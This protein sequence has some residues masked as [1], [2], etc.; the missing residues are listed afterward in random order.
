VTPRAAGLLGRDYWLVHSAPHDTTTPE[1]IAAVVDE[2]VEWLLGLESAGVVVLSGP[3]LDG[4]GARPGSGMTVLRAAD[5]DAA[6]AIADQDP[7]VTAGLRTF[8]LFR[9]RVNEGSIA[10]TVELGSGS[11][12]WH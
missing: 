12:R 10:V 4:P 7:F 3:L 2:H 6:R 1:Q 9:W 5:A 11:F 8:D